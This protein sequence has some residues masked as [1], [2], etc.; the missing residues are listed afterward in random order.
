MEHY[1]LQ[2]QCESVYNYKT[3]YK[4]LCEQGV[5]LIHDYFLIDLKSNE[6][7]LYSEIKSMEKNE[8]KVY[9]HHAKQASVLEFETIKDSQ[10]F[11]EKLNEKVNR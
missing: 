1:F 6:T 9:V 5:V 11:F 3:R 4:A 2:H 8:K 7:L 10:E